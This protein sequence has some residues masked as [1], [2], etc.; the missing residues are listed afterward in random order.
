MKR[1]GPVQPEG[2]R[3]DKA[4]AAGMAVALSLSHPP[5]GLGGGGARGV[6]GMGFRGA[7]ASGSPW[8][9]RRGGGNQTVAPPT[10]R[11]RG[12]P[13]APPPPLPH[14]AHVRRLPEPLARRRDAPWAVAKPEPPRAPARA[15]GRVSR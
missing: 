10:S 2:Q 9:P 1:T 6:H 4:S 5:G 7:E 13:L 11:E 14:R 15:A 3:S 8:T 12:G